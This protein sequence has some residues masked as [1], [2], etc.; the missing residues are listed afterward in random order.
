[1]ENEEKIYVFEVYCEDAN[2]NTRLEYSFQKCPNCGSR[3]Y[4][5]NVRKSIENAKT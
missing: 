2:C 1:M 5:K 4:H 3:A